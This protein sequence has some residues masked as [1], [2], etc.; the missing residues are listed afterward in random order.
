VPN[1]QWHC[2]LTGG[3]NASEAARHRRGPACLHRHSKSPT[4]F[5][6][7]SGIKIVCARP[8]NSGNNRDRLV[9]NQGCPHIRE[10]TVKGCNQVVLIFGKQP[11]QA[12]KI[13]VVLIFGKQP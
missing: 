5:L 11:R 13:K 2:T 8:Y 7:G 9:K 10:T 4:C 12:C 1:C 3:R 6:K